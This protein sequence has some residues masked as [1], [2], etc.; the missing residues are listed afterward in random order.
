[1]KHLKLKKT[2]TGKYIAKDVD[3]YIMYLKGDYE[4]ILNEQKIRVMELREENRKIKRKIESLEKNEKA[5]SQVLIKARIMAN[6]MMEEANNNAK[7]KKEILAGEI[8]AH[9]QAIIKYKEKIQELEKTAFN[10]LKDIVSRTDRLKITRALENKSDHGQISTP[11]DLMR[12]LEN[13]RRI[14][15][16]S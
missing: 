6:Q 8:L 9:K 1:M 12:T 14:R 5:I 3:K 4:N 15:S 7:T 13:I 16:T 10:I 11:V 2:L